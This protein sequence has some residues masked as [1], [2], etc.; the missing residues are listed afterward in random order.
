MS[1]EKPPVEFG[2]SLTFI[3]FMIGFVL[4]AALSMIILI[5]IKPLLPVNAL[6]QY[7]GLLFPLLI[8]GLLGYRV[9]QGTSFQLP[10]SSSILRAFGKKS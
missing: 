5:L 8:G 6:V 7:A 2:P 1:S 3:Y 10:L 9:A 4:G